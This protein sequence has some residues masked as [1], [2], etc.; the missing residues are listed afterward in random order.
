M[1]KK[2]KH[3]KNWKF[4]VKIWSTLTGN[5][6]DQFSSSTLNTEEIIH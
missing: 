5:H 6:T 3:N 1:Q 4:C 2:Y